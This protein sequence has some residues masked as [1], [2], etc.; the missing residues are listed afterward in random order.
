LVSATT[1]PGRRCICSR[2][3]WPLRRRKGFVADISISFGSVSAFLKTESLTRLL[4]GR[5]SAFG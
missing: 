4:E 2:L 5:V 3:R 1:S